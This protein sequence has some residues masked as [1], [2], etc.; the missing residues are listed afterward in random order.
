MYNRYSDIEKFV[1]DPNKLQIVNGSEVYI[2]SEE[3]FDIAVDLQGH[4]ERFEQL[5]PFIIFVAQRVCE[6]DN[7][8]QK[9]DKL[10]NG[11]NHFPYI[12]STVFIDEPYVIFEYWGTEENTQFD[13]VFERSENIFI[14]KSF[15]TIL[16]IPINWEQKFCFAHSRKRGNLKERLLNRLKE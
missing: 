15:G 9:F 1:T 6:L 11:N 5:K 12:V 4:I 3:N 7:I 13:V 2:S 10:Y 8:A 16:D 14:L